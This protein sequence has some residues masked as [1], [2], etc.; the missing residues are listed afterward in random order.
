MA[1]KPDI[2]VNK[3]RLLSS[4][5]HTFARTTCRILTIREKSYAMM[6]SD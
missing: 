4:C 6:S 2:A 1:E 5:G 3:C